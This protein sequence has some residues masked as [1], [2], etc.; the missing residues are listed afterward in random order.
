VDPTKKA[1]LEL[2]A[3]DLEQMK[4]YLGELAAEF[5]SGPATQ[6]VLPASAQKEFA[7]VIDQI[8]KPTAAG[9]PYN[10]YSCAKYE[11]SD[12]KQKAFEFWTIPPAATGM[13]PADY[14]TS[15]G[16]LDMLLYVVGG[17]LGQVGLDPEALKRFP[18]YREYPVM[19]ILYKEG[20]PTVVYRV[21]SIKTQAMSSE[22]FAVPA[23]YPR[24]DFLDV[25]KAVMSKLSKGPAKQAPA[26]P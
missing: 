8:S 19:T 3:A 17:A 11:F 25:L 24:T 4:A 21:L 7:A 26:Q 12:K 6:R 13:A 14:Q 1:I 15:R 5:N 9:V 20:K 22:I 2:T 16:L 23:N 18:Y 10:G